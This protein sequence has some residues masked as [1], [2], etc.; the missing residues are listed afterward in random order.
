MSGDDERKAAAGQGPRALGRGLDDVAHHFFSGSSPRH[1]E[2]AAAPAAEPAPLRPVMRAGVAVL[3]P[4]DPLLRAQLV[5]TLCE[6]RTALEEG[7]QAIAQGVQIA[8]DDAFDLAAVDR[9]HRF[10]IVDVDTHASDSLLTRGMSHVDWVSRNLPL[11]QRLY[12]S[13]TVDADA[14]PRLLLV[15]PGFSPRVKSAIRR[16]GSSAITCFTYRSI[17]VGGGTGIYVERVYRD[18][19]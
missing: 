4:G 10:A 6:C 17:E 3:R 5:A 8:P 18:D 9:S 19:D 12:P 13:W 2:P 11:V 1:G 16:I 7:L 15:A 14:P